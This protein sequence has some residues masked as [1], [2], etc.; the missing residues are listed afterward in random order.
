MAHHDRLLLV[1]AVGGYCTSPENQQIIG[2][3]LAAAL[4]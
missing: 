4:M 2:R 1:V 3:A